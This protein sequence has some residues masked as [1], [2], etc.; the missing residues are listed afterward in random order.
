MP[1]WIRDELLD[2]GFK[3]PTNF[4]PTGAHPLGNHQGSASSQ[5]KKPLCLQNKRM[6]M[7]SSSSM[8][9]SRNFRGQKKTTLS[10]CLLARRLV[11]IQVP[12]LCLPLGMHSSS[13]GSALTASLLTRGLVG[14][15]VP[16]LVPSLQVV[17][18]SGL[19]NA[20]T[21]CA[22]HDCTVLPLSLPALSSLP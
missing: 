13:L 21:S 6:A 15:Q 9:K 8:T 16:W 12:W 1:W 11:C 17:C 14:I 10:N 18:L 5:C 3:L 22:T 7:T 20:A 2:L 19:L 4:Q